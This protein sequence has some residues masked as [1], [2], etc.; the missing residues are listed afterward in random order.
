MV[1][2]ARQAGDGL[3][4]SVFVPVVR[5]RK[6]RVAVNQRLVAVRMAVASSRRHR[7]DMR[8]VVMHIAAVHMLVRVFHGLVRMP[9]YVPLRQMQR[10]ADGHQRTGQ[11]QSSSDRLAQ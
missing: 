11:E 9:V 7:R 2:S 8:V 1:R 4:T 10:H 3:I 6:M 5:V